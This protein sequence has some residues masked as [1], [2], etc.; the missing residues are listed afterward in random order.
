[1][2][3]CIRMY[4]YIYIYIHIVFIHCR[5]VTPQ[6]T[7]GGSSRAFRIVGQ[8]TGWCDIYGRTVE[9]LAGSPKSGKSNKS[10]STSPTRSERRGWIVQPLEVANFVP[11][12]NTSR[13]F[14]H[15]LLWE[16]VVSTLGAIQLIITT[17]TSRFSLLKFTCFIWRSCMSQVVGFF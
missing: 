7:V 9:S 10:S 3:V 17:F 8:G 12:D 11:K 2:F 1:M 4:M 13:S 16:F 15:D 5:D 6:D 14:K